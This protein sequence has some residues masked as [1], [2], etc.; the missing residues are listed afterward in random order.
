[1]VVEYVG[2]VAPVS[3]QRLRLGEGV[4]NGRRGKAEPEERTRIKRGRVAATAAGLIKAR[5]AEG[6]HSLVRWLSL[7]HFYIPLFIRGNYTS[8][9]AARLTRSFRELNT[10]A[11]YAGHSGSRLRTLAK[12]GERGVFETLVLLDRTLTDSAVCFL[13]PV[14]RRVA[15]IT[16]PFVSRPHH[17]SSKIDKY[18]YSQ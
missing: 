14:A 17:E 12:N 9:R 8:A 1:M 3:F 4:A 18:Q 2:R 16:F 5:F 15:L 11:G 13:T 10:R 6:L 7:R